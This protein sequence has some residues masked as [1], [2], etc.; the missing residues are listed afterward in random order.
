MVTLFIPFDYG[1]IVIVAARPTVNAAGNVASRPMATIWAA[2][3]EI[4][5][6]KNRCNL[7]GRGG[8]TPIRQVLCTCRHA[9]RSAGG[10]T[11]IHEKAWLAARPHLASLLGNNQSL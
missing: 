10:T 7:R 8:P 3:L 1:F 4:M 5:G 11:I 9:L 6:C 2:V